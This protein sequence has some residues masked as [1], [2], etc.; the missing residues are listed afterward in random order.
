MATL[1]FYDATTFIMCMTLTTMLIIP[2]AAQ[3]DRKSFASRLGWKKE[4]RVIIFHID[5]AGMSSESNRGTIQALR[6]G[7]ATSCS[8]MMPCPWATSMAKFLRENSTIDAGLHLTHTSEWNDYRWGPLIGIAHAPG[9]A[10]NEGRFWR[11]VSDVVNHA[12]TSEIEQETKAQIFS[13]KKMGYVP[14]HLDTHMGTLWASHEY[15]ELYIR[16]GLSEH[17]PILL[18]AG[19]NTLLTDQLRA[20][21]LAGLKK[22]FLSDD[23]NV[24]LD[25]LRKVGERLWDGGLAVVDDLYI[26]SYDWQL[27]EGTRITDE[28]LRKFKTAKYKEL[29]QSVKPGITVILVHCADADET[30]V[31]ISDSW[32]TRRADLLSLTD[33][34]LKRF[35]SDQNIML[36]TW[37]ELQQRRDALVR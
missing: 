20:G 23:Q 31:P 17:I 28:N 8:V 29:L 27:P 37:R 35:I 10:D 32:I 3:K 22:V 18:P 11:N 9:L 2:A 16:I 12:K 6:Y 15:V 19:H 33:P 5:D 36:T 1:N 26:L 25:S 24:V 13:A 4:D 7:I 30:F 21:P 34:D 14:T